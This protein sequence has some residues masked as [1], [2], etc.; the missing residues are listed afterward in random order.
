MTA[1]WPLFDL[2]LRL[3]D[4]LL[5]PVAEVDLPLLASI[6]PDDVDLDPSLPS[7]RSTAIHQGYWR[8]QSLWS[9]EDWVLSFLV[10]QGD[11]AVGVQILEGKDFGLLR[12]V[13]SASWLISAARGR[14]IGKA[15]RAAVLDF[16]FKHLE[17]QAAVTAAWHDNHASLGVS[18]S[19]GYLPNG[20]HWQRRGDRA[21]LMVHLRLTRSDWSDVDVAVEGFD[22]CRELFGV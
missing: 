2:R 17:A 6:L 22:S 7:D 14:G 11:R 8:A 19:L 10:Q 13:D 5:R 1:V 16:S 20:E 4:V 9:A 18:R 12:T 3:G 15:M 21:D